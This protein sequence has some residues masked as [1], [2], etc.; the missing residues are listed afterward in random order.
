MPNIYIYACLIIDFFLKKNQ[1]YLF[2]LL[3]NFKKILRNFKSFLNLIQSYLQTEIK[4]YFFRE[5]FDDYD[6]KEPSPPSKS[7]ISDL[8]E[9]LFELL[10]EEIIYISIDIFYLFMKNLCM[11]QGKENIWKKFIDFEVKNLRLSINMDKI[12]ASSYFFFYLYFYIYIF[13]SKIL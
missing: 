12:P 10:K 5:D 6:F 13:D 8:L 3:F 2:L 9:P 1:H 11:T 7:S 4:Y